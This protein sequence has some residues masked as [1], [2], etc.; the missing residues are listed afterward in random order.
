MYIINYFQLGHSIQ[1]DWDTSIEIYMCEIDE[2]PK[3]VSVL[4]N[5]KPHKRKNKGVLWF[6]LFTGLKI[7]CW[8]FHADALM[9]SAWPWLYTSKLMIKDAWQMQIFS[10]TLT[11]FTRTF[12]HLIYSCL[13]SFVFRLLGQF[14][15][16]N[17]LCWPLCVFVYV[18]LLCQCSQTLK[19]VS[20]Q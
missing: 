8:F 9:L 7:P 2:A 16:M 18:M 20:C 1:I 15:E 17:I 10:I 5:S 11:L 4:N 13:G 3:S 19:C 12:Y 6:I 14:A